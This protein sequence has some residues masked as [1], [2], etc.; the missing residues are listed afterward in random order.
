[1]NKK[2]AWA[3]VGVF[4]LL[5]AAKFLSGPT[6]PSNYGAYEAVPTPASNAV[7]GCS[8]DDISIKSVKAKFVDECRASSCYYMKGV[9]VLTN[10]CSEPIGVQVKI[11]A[12]DKDGA[13]LATRELWPA[14]VKNIPPGDYTFS[15]DTWLDYDPAIAKFGVSPIDIRRW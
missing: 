7:A 15:M 3:V 5:V 8:L 13:P 4:G 14:S 11:T 1:M 2:I 10:G 9:G 12:Y 6:A